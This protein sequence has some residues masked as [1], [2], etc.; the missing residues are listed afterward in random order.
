MGDEINRCDDV[1]CYSGHAYA[2]RPTALITGQR[3]LVVKTINAEWT[4]P[5]GKEF[6][7]TTNE[8]SRYRLIYDHLQETWQAIPA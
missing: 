6:L 1:I 8:G 3:R 2:E 7:V 5:N 4:S